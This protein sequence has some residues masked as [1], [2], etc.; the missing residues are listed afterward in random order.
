VAYVFSNRLLHPYLLPAGPHHPAYAATKA[1]LRGWSLACYEAL[2]DKN[3]KVV[4]VSPG[5]I[6][7]TEMQ[8]QTGKGEQQ[9]KILPEDVAEACLFAFRLSENCVPSEI[10]LKAVQPVS[11]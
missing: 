4:L 11:T 10:V 2:R 9:G 7:G 8:E 3:I 5:N 1:G 6:A